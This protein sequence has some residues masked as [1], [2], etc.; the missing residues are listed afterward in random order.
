MEIK[1]KN[2]DEFTDWIYKKQLHVEEIEEENK[3]LT[4]EI[5]ELKR[6]L[7]KVRDDNAMLN[8]RLNEKNISGGNRR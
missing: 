3:E 4:S 7:I 2:F 5:T 1:F 6:E 8:A